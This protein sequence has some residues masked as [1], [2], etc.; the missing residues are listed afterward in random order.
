MVFCSMPFGN[1]SKASTVCGDPAHF[2]RPTRLLQG[3]R[4]LPAEGGL[5]CSLS[6]ACEEIENTPCKFSHWSA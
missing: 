6:C 5:G 4:D 2:M 1:Y 3:S